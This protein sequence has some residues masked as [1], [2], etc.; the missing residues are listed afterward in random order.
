MGKL[1]TV[2]TLAALWLVLLPSQDPP[3]QPAVVSSLTDQ[4]I[5]AV[6]DQM[7]LQFKS[8]VDQDGLTAFHIMEGET[9]V[10]SIYQYRADKESPVQS[11]G[12]TTGYDMASGMIWQAANRWNSENRFAKV[13][14]DDEADPFLTYDV[15]VKGGVTQAYLAECLK[16]YLQSL[17][18]FESEFI[19]EGK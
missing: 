1:Q 10:C 12:F 6:L 2:C 18:T 16:T 17:K 19:P 14:L 9:L 3:A 5:Q 7:K 13:H 11:L 8:D 15:S 4:T